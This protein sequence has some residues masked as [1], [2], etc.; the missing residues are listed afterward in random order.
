MEKEGMVHALE[1]IRHLLKPGS[2]LI[3]IHPTTKR[4]EIFARTKAGTHFIG[5]LE[6][7]DEGI[8][9]AQADAAL[10][11]TIREGTFVLEFEDRF[12]FSSHADT[13][14]SLQK[15]LA[16]DWKDAVL[17]PGVLREALA[18][19]DAPGGVE[20]IILT[21]SVHIARLRN[22]GQG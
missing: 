21:E 18:L 14:Q 17:T 13:I 22:P 1:T 20:A 19:Q 9:Y 3:D 12:T 15:Y 16:E 6:E 4:P 10:E 8:E 11:Q 2:A 7:T 5:Y